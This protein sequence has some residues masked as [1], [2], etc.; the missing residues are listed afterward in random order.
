MNVHH[1]GGS[2]ALLPIS[3]EL[4]WFL[5]GFLY[6]IAWGLWLYAVVDSRRPKE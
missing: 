6:G 5:F 2:S 3:P 4:L 1:I